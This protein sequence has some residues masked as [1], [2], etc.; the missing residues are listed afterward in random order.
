MD[1]ELARKGLR[2][3]ETRAATLD[4]IVGEGAAAVPDILPLLQDR[5]DGIRWCAIKALSEIGDARAVGPLIALLEQ[6]KNVTE[7]AN[8]LRAITGQKLGDMA[9]EWRRWATQSRGTSPV[10]AATIPSD[11]ELMLAATRDLRARVSVDGQEYTV[12]VTLPRG[13]TQQVWVDFS[14]KDR[15]GRPIVRLFSLCGEADPAQYETVLKLNM[16]IPIGAIGLGLL[17]DRLYFAAVHSHLRATVHPE[18]IANSILAIAD[19]ADS[20]EASLAQGDRY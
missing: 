4:A 3:I 6:S 5:N 17:D 9:G 12:E 1:T 7:T 20:L 19:C 8:A 11:A 13:R 15:E 18:D 2:A 14:S 16:S 10:P